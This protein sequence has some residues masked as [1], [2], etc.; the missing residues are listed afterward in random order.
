MSCY[1][2]QI[3]LLKHQTRKQF[4]EF[5]KD[6]LHYYTFCSCFYSCPSLIWIGI[7][8]LG[9][10]FKALIPPIVFINCR[11]HWQTQNKISN[12][13]IKLKPRQRPNK[14]PLVFKFLLYY[15]FFQSFKL[16]SISRTCSKIQ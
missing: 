4:I 15:H 14:P 5:C 16:N 9:C 3:V 10:V 2:W 12:I 13:E 8:M 11:Q 1:I 7:T 6:E